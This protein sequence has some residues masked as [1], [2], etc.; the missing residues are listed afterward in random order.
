LEGVSVSERN[1]AAQGLT[2]D[3]ADQIWKAVDAFIDRHGAIASHGLGVYDRSRCNRIVAPAVERILAARQS[4]DEAAISERVAVAALVATG[5]HTGM[6]ARDALA[7]TAARLT[8]T[9][10]PEREGLPSACRSGDCHHQF[11]CQ[12]PAAP[13][14]EVF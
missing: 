5:R 11:D 2:E 14:G 10:A 3:E 1:P 6:T 9:A 7:A 13:E 12:T 4:R 8:D